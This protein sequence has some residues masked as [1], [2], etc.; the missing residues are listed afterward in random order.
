[1]SDAKVGS[2]IL[3]GLSQSFP[4]NLI[5]NII[6]HSLEPIFM[7]EVTCT[8]QRHDVIMP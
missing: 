7:E 4:L 5:L 6:F 1:M 3:L 2:P 8:L